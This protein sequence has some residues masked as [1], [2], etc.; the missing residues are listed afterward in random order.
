MALVSSRWHRPLHRSGSIYCDGATTL[1]AQTLP[2][3]PPLQLLFFIAPAIGLSLVATGALNAAVLLFDKRTRREAWQMALASTYT[4]H[5]IVC[6]LGKVGYRVVGQLRSA[7]QEVVVIQRN[8]QNEFFDLT[9][10]LGVPVIVG[11]ARQADMLLQAGLLR[12]H[13]VSIVTNDDLTNLDIALTARELRPDVQIVMRVFN[14]A[15]ARKLASAFN[16]KTAFSTS[17]L[18]APTFAAAAINRE[19]QNAIYVGGQFLVTQELKVT[20]GGVLDGQTVGAIEQDND[21]S[22]LY[23]RNAGGEDLRPKTEERLNAGDVIVLIGV[24]ATLERLGQLN[25]ATGS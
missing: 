18:A 7:G 17:A 13:S 12:A 4:N 9:L 25:K 8:P 21:V 10:G 6:G 1:P 2:T 19:V 24:L 5:I 3:A 16:I 15:L 20:A 11:D 22:I 14:D 23:R